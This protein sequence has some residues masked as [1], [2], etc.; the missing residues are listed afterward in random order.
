MNH[1]RYLLIRGYIQMMLNN[2]V[3]NSRGHHGSQKDATDASVISTYIMYYSEQTY[4]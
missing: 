3:I 1:C 4:I 2:D